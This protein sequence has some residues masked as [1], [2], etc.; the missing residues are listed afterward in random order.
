MGRKKK[1]S[2]AIEEKVKNYLDVYELD[3]VNAV[4]DLTSIRSM[5]AL[6]LRMEKLH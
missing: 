1:G 3:E 5:C 6:E 2:N 4:N